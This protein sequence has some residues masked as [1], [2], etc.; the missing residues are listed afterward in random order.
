MTEIL[1][2]CQPAV[3]RA[4]LAGASRPL[5]GTRDS[6]PTPCRGFHG[7]TPCAMVGFLA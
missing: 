3:M 2:T 4:G 6:A 1:D 7:H 5:V